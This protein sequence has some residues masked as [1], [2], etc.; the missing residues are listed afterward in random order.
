MEHTHH[1]NSLAQAAAHG[2]RAAAAT[3]LGADRALRAPLRALRVAFE[4]MRSGA[5]ADLAER[6]LAELNRAEHAAE[7]LVAWSHERPL[8]PVPCTVSEVITS[9]RAVLDLDDRSRCHLVLDGDDAPMTTDGRL[10]VDA[11][12]R[13]IRS[14]LKSVAEVMVH[15]HVEGDRASFNVVDTPEEE[16]LAVL[17]DSSS[18]DAG[19]RA[20]LAEEL[21]VRDIQRL[22]GTVA[23]RATG[24]HRCA[25][26][27]VPLVIPAFGQEVAA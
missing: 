23:L 8:R 2:A 25:L 17:F 16:E 1:A 11:L 21:L 4:G 14:R 9:L 12:E 24:T 7:D 26:A 13:A 19:S 6:A 18:D 27:G 20:T 15:V 10:L 22:G 5:Q 3:P